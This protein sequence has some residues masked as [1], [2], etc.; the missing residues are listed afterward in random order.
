MIDSK[1]NAEI[2]LD[3][4]LD[5]YESRLRLLNKCGLYNKSC[6]VDY[7]SMYLNTYAKPL[8]LYGIELF[9]LND[10]QLITSK[11]TNRL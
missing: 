11:I 7:R 5:A 3:S 1:F 9:H 2:H 6:K 4:R 10:M 8:L